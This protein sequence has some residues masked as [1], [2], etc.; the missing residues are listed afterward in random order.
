MPR[1]NHK[2]T[3]EMSAQD[4]ARVMAMFRSGEFTLREICSQFLIYEKDVKAIA[5][6]FGYGY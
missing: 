3:S 2:K 5:E 6:E 4:K 1:R